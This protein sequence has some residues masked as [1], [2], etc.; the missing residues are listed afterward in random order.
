M[1]YFTFPPEF[2][3]FDEHPEET[4]ANLKLKEKISH[5]ESIGIR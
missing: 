4:I 2:L 3:S 1:R 5:F